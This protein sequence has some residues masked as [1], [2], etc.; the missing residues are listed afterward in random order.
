MKQFE[1]HNEELRRFRAEAAELL[2]VSPGAGRWGRHAPAVEPS[3][4][5]LAH[6]ADPSAARGR[7]RPGQSRKGPNHRFRPPADAAMPNGPKVFAQP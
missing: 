1:P 6:P 5:G 4:A 3:Q 7:A 2:G